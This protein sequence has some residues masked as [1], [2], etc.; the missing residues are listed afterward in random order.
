MPGGETH[1]KAI[2]TH[3]LRGA[4]GK[5]MKTVEGGFEFRGQRP[6]PPG[7]ARGRKEATRCASS[8]NW[9]LPVPTG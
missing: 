8:R 2:A 3:V 1:K 5:K 7:R 4:H 6:L 9:M